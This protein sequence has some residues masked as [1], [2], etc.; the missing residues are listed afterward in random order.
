M[1]INVSTNGDF[2]SVL[3]HLSQEAEQNILSGIETKFPEEQ[4]F[5]LG[6]SNLH[7]FILLFSTFIV[8]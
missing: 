4:C 1:E 3:S 5:P 7:N 2:S 6:I 8:I